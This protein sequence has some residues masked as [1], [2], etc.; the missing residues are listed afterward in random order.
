MWSGARSPQGRVE[1]AVSVA[2]STDASSPT[3]RVNEALDERLL[4]IVYRAGQGLA[5]LSGGQREA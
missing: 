2:R 4:F 1:K 5:V 3:R